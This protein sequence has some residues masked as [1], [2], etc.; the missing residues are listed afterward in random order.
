[1][2]NTKK[3]KVWLVGAGPG[4][5][6]LMTLKG[7]E[8][9]ES[10][11]TVVYDA[12]V[13]E[14]VLAMM[15]PDAELIYVGKRSGRHT[16]SQDGI[17]RILLEEAL[18]GKT[19]VRLKG[20]DPFL[21]G[22][23]GEELELLTENGI[24]YGIVPGVTSAFSVPA[25]AG[26]PVTHRDYCSGVSVVTGHRK[27]D[28]SL[29]IDFDALV[30]TGDTLIFMMSVSSIGIIAEGLISAGMDPDT[31]AAIVEK[32]TT[33]QQRVLSTVL[34]KLHETAVNER[35]VAPSVIVVGGVADLSDRF[36][37]RQFL[38]LS[39]VRAIVTRPKELSSGLASML[40]E[41]GVEVTELPAIAIKPIENNT[42]LKEAI[43]KLK[44]GLYQWIV[45]TSPSGVRVFIE[46]LLGTCDVRTL[47]SCRIAAIGRGTEKE[48]AKY[49][50]RAD[51]IPSVYDGRTLGKELK[52]LV[53][54]GEHVLIPRAA[55]G[56]HEL[57][58]ELSEV[59]G[60]VIDDI[61][62]YDTVYVKQEW[63][64]AGKAFDQAGTYAVFTSASTV[65][66]FVNSYPDA[67][68]SKIK[69]VCIGRMTAA[70]AEKHGMTVFVSEEATLGS[71]VNKLISVSKG[72][73]I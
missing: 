12:L 36:A 30:R 73:E 68:C 44:D 28:G 71:L 25:Y 22:R 67:D 58:E 32:G 17:N 52:Q 15:P 34:G 47:A 43:I 9:L 20:G 66:G 61:A 63:F 57:I 26:I 33:S 24:E 49:G 48:L 38:P 45:L 50:L 18:K 23:G 39:G 72:Q 8:I 46:E 2:G 51:M 21:F 10:A 7:R 14:G 59:S 41:K 16:V 31:P 35:A 70:E 37:W 62:T 56:N 19:V 64:D 5:A 4:D 29:D 42:A 13:G 60:I 6:S 55:I 1:M 11:D 27:K 3:G 54:E 69:A 40:R 65:K 53:K